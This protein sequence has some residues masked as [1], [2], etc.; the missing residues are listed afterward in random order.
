MPVRAEGEA[1]GRPVDP[2]PGPSLAAWQIEDQ[3]RTRG[4]AATEFAGVLALTDHTGL[5]AVLES[6]FVDGLWFTTS[7]SIDLNHDPPLWMDGSPT[8]LLECVFANP[9][10]RPLA[11][12]GR[13]SRAR[14]FS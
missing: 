14:R 7:W 12:D 8:S 3:V 2:D 13:G 6:A 5:L 10:C 4:Q 9:T 1:G 11:G